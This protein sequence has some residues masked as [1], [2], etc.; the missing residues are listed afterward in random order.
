[1]KTTLIFVR[2]GE[3]EGNINRIFHGW[4]DGDITPKGRIQAQRAAERLKDVHI[5]VL[6]SS[7]LCRTIKTAEYISKAKNLPIIRTDKLKEINGGDW[8]GVHWDILSK[9]W[10]EAY[11]TWEHNPHLHQMPNGESMAEFQ[12]R[13]IAEIRHIIS[14]NTG[15]V[16]CI[17][18]HGTVIKSLICCFRH[19][20]LD[21][22]INVPWCDN[23]AITIADYEDDRFNLVIEGDASHLGDEFTTLGNQDW[24][25]AAMKKLKK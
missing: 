3:A 20:P 25:I 19:C 13:L 24:W 5:D 4:T 10:P 6:Y 15:K 23:T 7:T 11:K 12:K 22:M 2:H 14:E 16:I 1:M 17:V 18:T 8:E 9:K 21:E